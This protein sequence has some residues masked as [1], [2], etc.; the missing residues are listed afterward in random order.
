MTRLIRIVEE[1][2]GVLQPRPD[3]CVPSDSPIKMSGTSNSPT[4]DPEVVQAVTQ[5]IMGRPFLEQM[6]EILKEI[7][8]EEN[9]T[10]QDR[11][12]RAEGEPEHP[13]EQANPNGG[14]SI[15]NVTV[16]EILTIVKARSFYE[17][18]IFI[19]FLCCRV[20]IFKVRLNLMKTL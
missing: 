6:K 15:A 20:S 5:V 19:M 4:V 18:F 1:S 8:D 17:H 14:S 10:R 12:V 13:T 2:S 3:Q 16:Q 11:T 7:W 9:A